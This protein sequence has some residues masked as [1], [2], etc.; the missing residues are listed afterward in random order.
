M[1]YVTLYI[2][3]DPCKLSYMYP[4]TTHVYLDDMF[5]YYPYMI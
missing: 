3:T 2:Y 4:Y 5:T 1:V